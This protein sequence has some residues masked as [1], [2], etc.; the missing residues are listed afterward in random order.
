[1]A[2]KSL[3]IYLD[4]VCAMLDSYGGRDKVL[5]FRYNYKI[6]LHY[7]NRSKNCYYSFVK[8]ETFQGQIYVNLHIFTNFRITFTFANQCLDIKPVIKIL[9]LNHC[10]ASF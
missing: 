7:K 1:M 2:R 9:N 10:V 5:I 4:E 6:T 8:Y 3:K